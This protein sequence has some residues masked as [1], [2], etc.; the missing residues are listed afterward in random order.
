MPP[1]RPRSTLRGNSDDTTARLDRLDRLDRI[2]RAIERSNAANDEFRA[3]VRGAFTAQQE[4]ITE[5]RKT[6]AD[7]R[8]TVD[9]VAR[10]WQ[11]YLRTI[12]QPQ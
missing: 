7:L 12:H 9:Q 6:T 2:E 4:Q 11:A 10:E 3:I 5:L 1:K 8:D